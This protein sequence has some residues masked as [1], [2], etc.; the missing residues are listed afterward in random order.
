MKRSKLFTLFYRFLLTLALMLG[1]NSVLLSIDLKNPYLNTIAFLIFIA[2]N[3]FPSLAKGG[4]PSFAVR[5]C[6]HGSE[7][8]MQFLITSLLSSGIYI[9]Y[10]IQ[11]LPDRWREWVLCLIV[12]ILAESVVFWNG[13]IS[14]Y[15]SSIQLG[16]KH[17]VIGVLCGFIPIANIFCLG[18]IIKI[19][20]QEVN[21]EIDR[22]MLNKSRVGEQ[23]CRT[24]YPVLMV[25]G[26]FFRD[27][28]YFNYWGRVPKDL[29]AN[30]ATVYYGNHASASSVD[31][32]AKELAARIKQ[33]AAQ[34]GC[35]KLNVIAHSKGGLDCR[36]AIA[37]YGAEDMVA[38]LTTIN[39]PHRGCGF[40]D[41]LLTKVPVS[42]KNK[43]ASAYNIALRKF[44]DRNP[45]FIA[46]VTDL[47]EE[48]CNRLNSTVFDSP[49][50]YYQSVGSKLN[51]A[52]SGKFPLNFSYNLVKYFDGANDG[53]VSEKSF[54]WGSKFTFLTTEGKRGISH[55]DMIDL[56]RENIKGFD[57]REFYVQ[58]VSDLR[59]S[60]F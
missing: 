23:I 36:K 15:C 48:S 60:G 25:H 35:Q 20:M 7:L 30:G 10:G 44:G 57:V 55:G 38:S 16:I 24:K 49:K 27:S 9:Y 18:I 32:S 17:R 43:I 42:V 41:Y 5:M 26:V 8:L 40:A 19:T 31:D 50:V 37:C 11:M 28:A 47:T 59:K 13:I 34:T 6:S 39:T 3:I 4:Y 56:N 46:A 21:F 58:L 29:I 22:A 52:G 51:K 2:A 53:L 54:P 14:V 12:A 33:I 1:I 45:D